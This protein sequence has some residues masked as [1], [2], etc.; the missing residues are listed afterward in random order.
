MEIRHLRSFVA[1]G[2]REH[3]GRAA[4]MLRLPQ[5]AISRH[6]KSL[7]EDLGLALF[8][9]AG[10]RMRLSLAGRF[11]L[12]DAKRIL[13]DVDRTRERARRVASGQIGTLRIGCNEPGSG[14][15]IVLE[16]VR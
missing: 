10:R 11:F 14:Y 9:R 5:P 3:F 2:E 1:A 13:N 4:E 6:I 15:P 7:E 12:E 8:E 16:T